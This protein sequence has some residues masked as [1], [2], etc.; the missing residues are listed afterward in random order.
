MSLLESTLGAIVPANRETA[1]AA[2]SRLAQVLEGDDSALGRL[3]GLLLRYLA[4]TGERHPQSPE[5]CTV[6]CCA[7]HGVAAEGVSAYPPETTVQMTRNY[8]ISRGGAAN[9]FADY[10][11]A[12]LLVVDMGIAADT[13]DIPDL[14]DARIANGTANMAQGPAMTRDQARQAVETGID[15]ANQ[16]INEGFDCI[17]PGEMGI[18]NTT[19]SAA[20]TAVCCGLSAEAVTG[21]GTN[22]SDERLRKKTTIVQKSLDINQP[23][24][25]DGLDILAKVGGFE[26]GAIAGLILGAAA[27]QRTIILDGANTAAAALIAQ[28]L[29]PDCVDYLLAS[30]QGAEKSHAHS[31]QKLGLEPLMDLDLKLGEACGSSLLA[32]MLDAALTAWDVLD[33]L[34]QDPIET[35]FH[36]E[37]MRYATPKITDKTF[38]FYLRTMQDLDHQSMELCQQRIDNLAK[39]IYSLGYLEQI[40]V[41][42]AGIIGDELPECGMDRALLVFTG[43]HTSPLQSQITAAFATHAG[44]EVTL[45]H[46]REGLPPTAAFDFGREHAE[47]LSLSYP[48]LGLALTEM[49]EDAPFGTAAGELRAALLKED[50]SLRYAAD[51]FLSKT[52]ETYQPA[53]SAIIGA[54]IAAAHNSSFILLDDEA[55]EIIA[56]Y[57]ELLC[58]AVRPYILHV[59]PALLQADITLPGGIIASLGLDI[60]EAAL[61][62]LNGMRTF[63]ETKVAVASDG[64]GAGRQLQ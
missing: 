26:L 47:L 27:R 16:V 1:A 34:P 60:T 18:A 3:R 59:Q 40:A 52:P 6:I 46:L 33:K 32:N 56:R 64:P 61:H 2:A 8:L 19:A 63:A 23:D 11:S 48:L 17:L 43:R 28:R 55:T 36:H 4:I 12:E 31:L 10:C 15:I 29:A 30:H 5:K 38:D 49:D 53:V 25:S 42:L 45:G 22:I 35:P 39:P 62:M 13:S 37:Y 14:I 44:A 7:D 58:P 20:I 21:R 54:I 57:T 9:A 41:E 24:E 51:E 50:G